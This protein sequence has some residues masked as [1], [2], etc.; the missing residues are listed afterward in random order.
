MGGT[1]QV[2]TMVVLAG[3]LVYAGYLIGHRVR[4]ATEK[5]PPV[6][7]AAASTTSTVGVAP[8]DI[9]PNFTLTTSTG[10]TVTL[11]QLRGH[12]VWLNFWATWCPYCNKEIPI[13]EQEAVTHQGQLDVVGV[14]V[15][16]SASK[17][18]T[19]MTA[20]HMTYPVVLDS[21]GAVSASY[22]VTGLPTSVFIRPD[23]RV[24]AL[25]TGA[26]L[27]VSQANQMLAQI[28]PHS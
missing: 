28:L 17:V 19:F 3:A 12:P 7:T 5:T 27:S 23:G 8:G 1:R 26:I 21:Q 15:E 4:T 6:A 14:D 2:L 18:N 13:V 16:E 9:A 24:G 22:G 10:Q 20:H 25:Y 11:S